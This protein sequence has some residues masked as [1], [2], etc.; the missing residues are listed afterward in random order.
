MQGLNTIFMNTKEIFQWL[1]FPSDRFERTYKNIFCYEASG[2]AAC[3]KQWEGWRTYS[4]LLYFNFCFWDFFLF[5]KSSSCAFA[6]CPAHSLG[7]AHIEGSCKNVL[8]KSVCVMRERCALKFI[9]NVKVLL[10]PGIHQFDS[11]GFCLSQ[12]FIFSLGDWHKRK[13]KAVKDILV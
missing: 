10:T 5:V 12:P 1:N 7:C 6:V 11:L 13:A 9:L 3:I 4:A 8:H 2:A